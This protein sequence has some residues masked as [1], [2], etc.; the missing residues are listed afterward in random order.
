MVDELY[1]MMS[2]IDTNISSLRA[3]RTNAE[4]IYEEVQKLVDSSFENRREANYY[5]SQF[6]ETWF[7]ID[8]EIRRLHEFKAALRKKLLQSDNQ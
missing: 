3:A 4:K 2:Y 7:N 1:R 6:D 5:L 8:D